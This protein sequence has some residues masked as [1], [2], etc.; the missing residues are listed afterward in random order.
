MKILAQEVENQVNIE[1][2]EKIPTLFST[3]RIGAT[4]ARRV[5]PRCAIDQYSSPPFKKN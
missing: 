1:E 5:N 2:I 4:L 3:G